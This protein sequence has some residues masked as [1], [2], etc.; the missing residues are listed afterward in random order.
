MSDVRIALERPDHPD[1]RALVDELDAY[2]KPLY[3]PESHHGI[4][5]DALLQPQVRFAAVRTVAGEAVGCGA[6]VLDDEGG[7]ELK[8]MY[9][10]EPWRG[11]GRARALL[12]FLESAGRDAGCTVLR[13]ET[14]IHQ[15]AALAFYAAAGY[16]RRGPFGSY[17]P[18]PLS[19]FMEKVI[20]E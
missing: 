16:L 3:P 10:R 14:G 19:V 1:L 8:R 6:L 5:L 2:Q 18:D 4:D 7:G 13:L 12:D 20:S 11:G 15:H 9:L 17:G